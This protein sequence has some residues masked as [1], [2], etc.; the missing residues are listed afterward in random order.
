MTIPKL[1][2]EPRDLKDD[3]RV[4]SGVRRFS[5]LANWLKYPD[6]S[7]TRAELWELL[8]RYEGGRAALEAHNFQKHC[9]QVLAH[10]KAQ[11][12][13]RRLWRWIR[14]VP[15]PAPPAIPRVPLE[16]M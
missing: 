13:Y 4:P 5:N 9:E 2:L 7:V 6:K 14:Q 3:G 1:P 15:P 8:N 16:E 12:W 10:L 11:V